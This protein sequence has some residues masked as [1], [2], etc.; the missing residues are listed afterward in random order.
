MPVDSAVF[1]TLARECGFGLSGIAAATP[2][3]DAAQYQAWVDAGHAGE[4]RYLTD[5]RAQK[6]ADPRSLLPTAQTV[7]CLGMLYNGPEP[8]TEAFDSYERGWISRYAWGADYHQ[9]I[10]T[11]LQQLTNR[12]QEIESFDYKICCD[13][14]PLLERTYAHEAGLGWIGRNSCLIHEGQGSWFFL[15]E[16][17]TS[18][19]LPTNSPPPDRCGTCHRCIEACPTEAIVLL[20]NRW[21]VDSRRCISYL[22]IELRGPIPE[23]HRT[24]MGPH[25][26]GC[27]ICQ[28]VC[29]WNRK[30]PFTP[31]SAF[32]PTHLAPPLEA[33]ARL[34]ETEFRQLFHNTP[35]D[36]ARYSGFLRNVAIAMGN[37]GNQ[38]LREPLQKL[39]SGPDAIV[40]EHARWALDKLSQ[41]V[42]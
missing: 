34:T 15:G 9:L 32:A 14:A 22:T 42:P 4:M 18:L 29:P 11:R 33:M 8:H 7:L 16:I 27:D 19:R 38:D 2:H 20:D 25:L 37:S 1:H 41:L 23:Q 13:T 5:H 3:P 39:E 17:L 28:D 12:L 26:F 35:I 10:S 36:R 24:G 30:A 40:A 31:E 6:R 21:C